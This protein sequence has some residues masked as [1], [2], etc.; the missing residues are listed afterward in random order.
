MSEY[1]QIEAMMRHVLERERVSLKCDED[2]AIG[3]KDELGELMRSCDA[4]RERI[5]EVERWL[6][7]FGEAA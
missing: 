3:I 6:K 7:N 1:P 4:K 5:A 2:R